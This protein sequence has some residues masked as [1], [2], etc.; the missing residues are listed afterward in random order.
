MRVQKKADQWW[1][2][3]YRGKQLAD[4]CNATGQVIGASAKSQRGSQTCLTK[5][6][7]MSQVRHKSRAR[8]AARPATRENEHSVP[9]VLVA[10][11]TE[12]PDQAVVIDARGF[13]ARLRSHGRPSH[14]Q[15][16]IAVAV[17]GAAATIIT[18]AVNGMFD[19]ADPHPAPTLVVSSPVTS[20]SAPTAAADPPVVGPRV[21]GDNSEFVA[22]LTYPDRSPVLTGQHFIKKWEL[23]NIGSVSWVNRY[24]I[25]D[26]SSTGRCAYP[27]KVKIPATYPG[28]TVVISVP[29]TASSTVGLC[30]VTW[31][32]VDAAGA[33]YFPGE[34]GIWFEVQVIR[35]HQQ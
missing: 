24:L 23:K 28:Q 20:S 6:A 35:D 19:L 4:R 27:P 5:G 2:G 25:P 15:A 12:T 11:H 7:M 18:A 34:I 32:M 8:K 16:G 21:P 22:D 33:L 30:L 9:S 10:D 3:L 14:T 31:K 17:I 13:L 26:G 29:V 1:S